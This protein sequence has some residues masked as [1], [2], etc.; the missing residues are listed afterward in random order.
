MLLPLIDTGKGSRH[1]IFLY[2]N[3]NIS[4]KSRQFDKL[5]L[6]LQKKKKKFKHDL[7]MSAEC[8]KIKGDN[9]EH[10]FLEPCGICLLL[11]FNPM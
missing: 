2:I 1:S 11:I 9:L 8:R 6:N 7:L 5:V 10:Q 3:P 4:Y